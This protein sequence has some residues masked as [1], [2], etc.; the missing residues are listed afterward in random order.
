MIDIPKKLLSIKKERCEL[1]SNLQIAVFD[2]RWHAI[3]VLAI[4][5]ITIEALEKLLVETLEDGQRQS[6]I[7]KTEDSPG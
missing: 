7:R 3:Q 5:L 4:Q 6:T 1:A 2:Q